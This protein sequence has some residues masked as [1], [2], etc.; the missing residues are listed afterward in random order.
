MAKSKSFTYPFPFTDLM[1]RAV[2]IAAIYSEKPEYKGIYIFEGTIQ[3]GKIS[4]PKMAGEYQLTGEMIVITIVKKP[5]L[6]PWK[7]I[8]KQIEILLTTEIEEVQNFIRQ[9]E[10]SLLDDQ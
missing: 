10:K 1:P 7:L 2:E 3:Y 4:S 5:L 9:A 8:E 6:V